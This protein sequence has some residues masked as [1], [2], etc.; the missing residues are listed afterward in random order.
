MK[1][2]KRSEAIDSLIEYE[3]VNGEMWRVMYDGWVGYKNRTN[4]QLEEAG[5]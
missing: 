3:V 1:T 5:E 4:R 2:I